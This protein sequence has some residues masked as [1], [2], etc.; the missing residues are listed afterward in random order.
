MKYLLVTSWNSSVAAAWIARAF[1]LQNIDEHK[2]VVLCPKREDSW[3]EDYQPTDAHTNVRIHHFEDDLIM[4][5]SQPFSNTGLPTL[6]YVLLQLVFYAKT[7]EI[8]K[9]LVMGS[10]FQN[11]SIL[12][13]YALL[14]EKDKPAVAVRAIVTH[15]GLQRDSEFREVEITNAVQ[16][17]YGLC[18][19][20]FYTPW[21]SDFIREFEFDGISFDP[22]IV[23]SIRI[24]RSIL[25]ARAHLK[26]V[27]KMALPTHS[28]VVCS[29]H[30]SDENL[31][32]TIQTFKSLSHDVTENDRVL[33]WIVQMAPKRSVYDLVREEMN[34]IYTYTRLATEVVYAMIDACDAFVTPEEFFQG[35]IQTRQKPIIQNE[36][37]RETCETRTVREHVNVAVEP[38]IPDFGSL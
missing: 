4:E 35:I 17:A 31:L 11:F 38:S 6:D 23:S 28:F 15:P 29:F 20:I 13:R 19:R 18:E 21:S 32:N 33:L 7:Y 30:A 16:K 5:D 3:A 1:V 22:K 10:F 37:F 14:E 8:D 12:A 27:V 25:S 34:I 24:P 26:D 36:S 9:I 2:F